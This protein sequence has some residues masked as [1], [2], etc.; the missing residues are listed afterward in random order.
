MFRT[1][2]ILIPFFR[3]GG[4]SELDCQYPLIVVSELMKCG[5]GKVD[6]LGSW[7]TASTTIH[8]AGKN[9]FF[10]SIA[11][12]YKLEAFRP[13]MPTVKSGSASK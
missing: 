13:V 7:L 6:M 3:F 5:A 4:M 2:K 10:R 1:P 12:L 9:T 8:Y 11:E